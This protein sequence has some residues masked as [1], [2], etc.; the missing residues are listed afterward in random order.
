MTHEREREGIRKKE[1]IVTA[2]FTWK[3]KDYLAGDVVEEN[4]GN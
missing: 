4:E 1:N 2:S 3:K